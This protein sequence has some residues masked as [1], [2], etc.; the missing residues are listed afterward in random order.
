MS[1]MLGWA[2]DGVAAFKSLSYFNPNK[3]IGPSSFFHFVL[4]CFEIRSSV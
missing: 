1:P 3:L 4:F 2:F